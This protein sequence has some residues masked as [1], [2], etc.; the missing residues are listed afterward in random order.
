MDT[1]YYFIDFSIDSDLSEINAEEIK[2][3]VKNG[4]ATENWIFCQID[5]S[6]RCAFGKYNMPYPKYVL[7]NRNYKRTKEMTLTIIRENFKDEKEAMFWNT[8]RF[9]VQAELNR[10]ATANS[11][12]DGMKYKFEII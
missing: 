7:V 6:I 8:Q 5:G 12:E 4:E 1:K 10:Q 3:F 9:F 2:G 11:D